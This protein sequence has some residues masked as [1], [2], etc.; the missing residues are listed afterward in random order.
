MAGVSNQP[1]RR[2]GRLTL[3][4][5][6]RAL[7]VFHPIANGLAHGEAEEAVIAPYEAAYE[8]MVHNDPQALAAFEA[9][10]DQHPD[11][12]LVQLHLK[13]LRQGQQGDVIV[14]DEK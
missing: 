9:L 11:D 12:P 3:K 13:R 10:A 5:K 6:S 14:M 2:I 4:G 8:L 7:L 1:V